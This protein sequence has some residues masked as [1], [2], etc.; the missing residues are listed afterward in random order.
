ME[1]VARVMREC[2]PLPAAGLDASA[3]LRQAMRDLGM[4]DVGPRVCRDCL[5]LT[6]KALGRAAADGGR[7][8]PLSK[9]A[10]FLVLSSSPSSSAAGAS[11]LPSS[12]AAGAAV[13]CSDR[14]ATAPTQDLM[15]TQQP[16]GE[17]GEEGG[18]GEGGDQDWIEQF[19]LV[20]GR[21]I[22]IFPSQ[23]DAFR[24]T[25]V[26]QTGISN[27]LCRGRSQ[28]GGYGWVW[29]CVGGW[30]METT[31]ATMAAT[32]MT[33]YVRVC[34]CVWVCVCEWVVGY[35]CEGGVGGWVWVWVDGSGCK[36]GG[37]GLTGAEHHFLFV[38]FTSYRNTV[39]F[40]RLHCS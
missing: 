4:R 2:N 17:E 28:A 34:R 32:T 8:I 21:V 11:C 1:T 40:S 3:V 36:T 13:L 5:A 38:S 7:L 18:D 27:A 15:Q 26:S 30:A 39:L 24:A 29:W 9:Q 14:R 10:F 31:A 12:V 37:C 33:V 25:G 35:V 19:D 23:M 20:T 22:A 16:D 6:E